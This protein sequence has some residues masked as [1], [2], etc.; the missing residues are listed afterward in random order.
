MISGKRPTRTIRTMHTGRE[1]DDEEACLAVAEWRNRFAVVIR[2]TTSDVIEE[3]RQ[4]RAR[5][6][7][8]VENRVSHSCTE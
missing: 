1:P 3:R 8:P 4:P 7:V 6:A 5:T 2:V